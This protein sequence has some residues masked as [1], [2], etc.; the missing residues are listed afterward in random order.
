M[1]HRPDQTAH[2]AVSD[3]NLNCLLMDILLNFWGKNEKYSPTSKKMEMSSPFYGLDLSVASACFGIIF[4]VYRFF[5]KSKHFSRIFQ[6]VNLTVW[7]QTRYNISSVLDTICLRWSASAGD[8]S[9]H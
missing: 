5:F 2:Y 4:A 9:P 7:I 3:Q 6:I 8:K 1:G